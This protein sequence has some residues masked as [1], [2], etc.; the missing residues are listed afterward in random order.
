MKNIPICRYCGRPYKKNPHILEGLPD[1]IKE[2]IIYIPDCDCLEIQKEKELEELERKRV[3]QCMANKIKRFR[4]ISLIDSKFKLSTFK[5]ADMSFKYMK[6]ALSFA[7]KFVEKGTAP[8]GILFY[9]GVGTGKTYASSCIANYLMDS[10]K[11]VVVMSIGLYIG[12]IQR[13]WA[14][15]EKELL[16]YIK[17]CDLLIIDDFGAEKISEFVIEKIFAMID[18]RYRSLKP[19]IITTNLDINEISTRF[20]ARISDRIVEMCFP[21]LVGGASKRGADTKREFMDFLT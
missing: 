2:K 20:G 21:I 5:R 9:G 14:E 12:K 16:S 10:G 4:D 1:F 15:A 7:R 17:A 13:E 8:K 6:L 3:A 19:V 18:A 11:T